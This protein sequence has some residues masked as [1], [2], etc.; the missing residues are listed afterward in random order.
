MAGGFAYTPASG[1]ILHAGAGQTLSATFTP[2]D[3][4]NYSPVTVTRKLDVSPVAPTITANDETKVAGD[5][6]PALS[7][8]YA[9]FVNGD[10]PACLAHPVVLSTSARANSPAGSYAIV[11]SAASSPD[12]AIR[13]SRARS[14]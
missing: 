12:H 6:I 5:P 4:I 10:G 13:S 9:G 1:M 2:T 7:A 11:A 14:R 8:S 3:T